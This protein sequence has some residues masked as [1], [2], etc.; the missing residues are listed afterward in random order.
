MLVHQG[1]QIVRVPQIA[2][3]S[4][5]VSIIVAGVIF[6]WNRWESHIQVNLI[7]TISLAKSSL[8]LFLPIFLSKFFIPMGSFALAYFCTI[9]DVGIFSAITKILAITTILQ[10]LIVSSFYP[11]LAR[12]L[13]DST[14]ESF[15]LS[16][17]FRTSLV[18]GFFI[19][20]LCLIF[21]SEIINAMFGI[22]YLDASMMLI[23][24]GIFIIVQFVSFTLSRLMPAMGREKEFGRIVTIGAIVFFV[25]CLPL[26]KWFGIVGVILAAFMSELSIVVYILKKISFKFI[27]TEK[28]KYLKSFFIPVLCIRLTFI[29]KN[30][31]VINWLFHLIIFTLMYFSGIL[32]LKIIL[33]REFYSQIFE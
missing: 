6:L 25:L 4:S 20:G 30:A 16:L 32:L 11:F 18:T 3:F 13:G 22:A 17:F 33:P 1:E 23:P 2:L 5:F 12:F 15:T 28:E 8:P 10:N 14:K 7:E 31:I 9:S 21:S 27:W 29:L 26:A 24:L 19:G